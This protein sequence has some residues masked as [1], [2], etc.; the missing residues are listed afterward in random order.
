LKTQKIWILS[1]FLSCIMVA[2]SMP[3]MSVPAATALPQT[4]ASP[5]P[6]TPVSLSSIDMVDENNGWAFADNRENPQLLR[7]TDGGQHWTDVTP[8]ELPSISTYGNSFLNARTA[9]V[10]FFDPAS[11][12]TGL[13]RTTDG[14]GTW[15]V[16]TNSL[17]FPSTSFHFTDQNHGWAKIM[18]GGAGNAYFQVHET[19]DG[20]KTWAVVPIL[21][22]EPEPDLSSGVV[23]LCNI[24]GDG[25]YYDPARI[26]ITYGDQ[27]TAPGGSVR[28][29]VSTDLGKTWHGLELP[30][31]S[32]Q[33]KDDVIV[34]M[35][36]VF[37]EG[38]RGALPVVMQQAD[39]NGSINSLT[40]YGTQ[41]G[42]VSWQPSPTVIDGVSAFARIDFVQPVDAFVACGNDL[43]VTHD[44]ARSWQVLKSNLVFDINA[45][46]GERV[47][48]FDFVNAGTGWAITTD[49]NGSQ[50]ALWQ[51]SDG[52]ESWTRLSPAVVQ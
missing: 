17:S 8:K 14:G 26:V 25:F 38:N 15:T 34:P 18:D 11:N 35:S 39:A 19:Q 46:T 33:H 31:T 3:G 40:V 28:L 42:G 36:P 29:A 37:F 10:Q 7:T 52:G 41:D 27:A 12:A 45:P 44:G 16:Q 43:C 50:P 32:E 13:A 23:H 22:P 4:T 6:S 49:T 20:G 2:C 30:L 47:S 21:G 51:T 9:W 24:C 48:H 5:M 1:S